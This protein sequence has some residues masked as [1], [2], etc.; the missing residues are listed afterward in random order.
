MS[1]DKALELECAHDWRTDPYRLLR[2]SP[3]RLVVVCASCGAAHTAEADPTA[4]LPPL[5]SDPAEWPAWQ[6]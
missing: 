1:D 2:M 4:K 5:A 3:D 6:P